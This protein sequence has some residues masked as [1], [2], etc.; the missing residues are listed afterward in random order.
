QLHRNHRRLS[1]ARRLGLHPGLRRGRHVAR[2]HGGRG[3]LHRHRHPHSPAGTEAARGGRRPMTRHGLFAFVRHAVLLAWTAVTLIPVY[4]MLNTSFKHS[5]EWVTWPPHWFPEQPTLENYAQVLTPGST[6]F[7]LGRPTLKVVKPL[8]DSLFTATA[9]ALVAVA[10]GSAL[11]YSWA[12]FVTGG[13]HYPYSV[14]T[15]R[16]LP[17]IV[18]AVPSLVYSV[19]LHPRDTY[20]G[21]IPA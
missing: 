15:I 21:P 6:I 4:W 3:H 16:M 18:I 12:P 11:A 20:A 5:G 2:P 1:L 7:E 13:K 9:S 19:S 17:P 14:L 10:L 8:W